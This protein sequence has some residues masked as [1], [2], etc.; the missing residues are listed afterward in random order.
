M[1]D[2]GEVQTTNTG[3]GKS[4]TL[5]GYEAPTANYSKHAET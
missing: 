2:D 1:R 4:T 3:R 5:T